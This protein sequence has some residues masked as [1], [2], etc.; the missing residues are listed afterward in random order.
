MVIRAQS[1]RAWTQIVSDLV[2]SCGHPNFRGFMVRSLPDSD[3]T[4]ACTRLV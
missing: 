4:A 3:G 2:V 1:A